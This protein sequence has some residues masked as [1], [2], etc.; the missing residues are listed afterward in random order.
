[1]SKKPRKLTENEVRKKFIHR[2]KT[3]AVYWDKV[4]GRTTLEKIE[5]AIFSTLVTLDGEAFDLPAFIVAPLPDKSDKEFCKNRGENWY[6]ENHNSQ[7]NCD[8]AGSLHEEFK[9]IKNS[10][11]P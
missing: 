7:V 1:M 6:P 11:K 4:K 8:I 9:M 10:K 2:L 5:G 3:T